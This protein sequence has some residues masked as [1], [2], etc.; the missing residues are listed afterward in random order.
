[1]DRRLFLGGSGIGTLLFFLG[2]NRLVTPPN[3]A[4]NSIPQA[5]FDARSE[6]DALV[7]LFGTERSQ[8]CDRI[9]LTVPFVTDAALGAQI[10]IWSAIE[11]PRAI[12]I[13]IRNSEHPLAAFVRLKKAQ[14]FFA[15]HIKVAKTTPVIA[16]VLTTDGLHSASK[17]V[18]VTNGGYGIYAH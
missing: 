5:A 4:A 7:A 14:C 10:K 18:K 17:T 12:A 11:S 9:N 13:M 15:T 2:S 1:M 3:A 6:A 16:H 8:P